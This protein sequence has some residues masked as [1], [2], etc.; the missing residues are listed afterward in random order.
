MESKQVRDLMEAYASIYSTIS[1]SHF[2]VGDEVICKKSGMEGEVI[3]VDPEEKGKYYTVKR[4]DGKTMK[5]APDELKLEKEEDEKEDEKEDMKEAKNGGVDKKTETKFHKKLD[6]LVHKT[7]GEREEEKKMKEDLDTVV[8]TVTSTVKPHIQDRARKRHGGPLGLFGSVAADRA[9][10]EVDAIGG[11][12]KSGNYGS[13]LNR[14]IKGASKLFNSYE[15]DKF[16]V[17]LE[18]LVAEGY[19]DTNKAALAIMTNMSEE[20]KQNIVE[21]I[22]GGGYTPNPVGNAIR[23]GAGLLKSVMSNPS[24]QGAVKTGSQMLKKKAPTGG[25]S[26]RPGDGKPYA[27]GPLWDGPETPV[28]KPQPQRKPQ[29]PMRDEPLW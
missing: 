4:E 13:A 11:D 10:K 23:T 8:D 12:V 27:D 29:A 16:D 24:V 18:Y 1:E 19:A 15:P 17:I 21:T 6:T 5:Y 28:K 7:F 26:T 25:Y 20:W 22:A 9:G 3:K 14:T 2:K